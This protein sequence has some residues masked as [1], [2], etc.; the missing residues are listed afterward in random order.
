MATLVY[1]RSVRMDVPLAQHL[2]TIAIGP[3]KFDKK[4]IADVQELRGTLPESFTSMFNHVCA[5]DIIGHIL[6]R[7]EKKA[8]VG[9]SRL[10]EV[11][12]SRRVLLFFERIG[13]RSSPR[14]LQD[15]ISGFRSRCR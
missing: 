13:H 5:T 4:F 8:L 1:L 9:I 12:I 7:I 10:L 11:R 2:G 14:E 3:S 6:E 15:R